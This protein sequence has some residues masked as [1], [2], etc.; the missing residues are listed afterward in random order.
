MVNIGL[1]RTRT[2]GCIDKIRL[3]L[4]AKLHIVRLAET[5]RCVEDAHFG[6]CSIAHA[7]IYHDIH[8]KYTRRTVSATFL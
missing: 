7:A 5:G 8:E 4:N 3:E 1:L 2:M 6:C